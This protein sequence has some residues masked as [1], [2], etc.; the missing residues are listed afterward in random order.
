M[1]NNEQIALA[2]AE[3]RGGTLSPIASGAVDSHEERT[4]L[5]Q[6]LRVLQKRRWLVACS[7]AAIVALVS[8]IS[9]LIPKRYEATSKVLLDTEGSDT[10]G[11]EQMVLPIGFD[12]NTKL[13]TQIRIAESDTI[14]ISVIQQLGLDHRREFAGRLASERDTDFDTRG[15]EKRAQ[16]LV[17]FRKSL[18]VRLIPKTQIIEIHFR[19]RDPRLASEV[20]NAVANTYIEHNF[21]VKYKATRQTSEWLAQQLDDL[22]KHAE[23]SQENFIAYQ[24]KTGILGTDETH[25]IITEKLDELN[26]RLAEAEGDRI[27]KEAKYRIATSDNPELMANVLPESVLGALYRQ[28]AEAKARLAQMS[29]KYGTAYPP[30]VQLKAELDDLHDSVRQEIGRAGDRV[31]AEYQASLRSEQMLADSLDRQKQQAYKL[32]GA[33]IQYAIL[34]RDV[35]SSRDL[36][37]GLLKKLKEAGILAGL[38]SSNI[39]IIDPASVPVEPMEPK[40][41]LNIGLGCL[42]GLLLGVALAFVAENVDTSIRT[43][44]D[45]ES[46][47]SMP[48]FGIIPSVPLDG[49]PRNRLRARTGVP[50]PQLVTI[51]DRNSGPAEAFR[52]LRTSLLLCS[53]KEPPQV[54]LVSSSIAQEGKSFTAANLSVVL[55]QTGKDVLLIDTDMR[56]PTVHRSFGIPMNAGL[57]GCLAGTEDPD[58]VIVKVDD[59]PGLHVVASG[60]LPPYPSELL[61]SD[62]MP[63]LLERWR[64]QYRYI[65]VDTP[66]VLAVTDATVCAKL[67]DVVVL[68]ARSQQTGRQSLLR[69]RD[70]LRKVRAN[71][72]G[73]VVNDLAFNSV[74]YR[75]YYGYYGNGYHQYYNSENRKGEGNRNGNGNRD[76]K[77]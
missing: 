34:R 32:N 14:A 7:L 60:H 2:D 64:K 31:R 13:Q 18:H 28:H 41:P 61:A 1:N 68:I 36:Y 35:E 19:S 48:S 46:Y 75:Q 52:A 38:K 15:I 59:I 22:K 62:A 73:V 40:I 23:T 17:L 51:E 42:G 50:L 71:V 55:A 37:E 4:S 27:V 24:K 76:G 29:A 45:I 49:K 33:A 70:L 43:P 54:F 25:N 69:T 12:L 74:E 6:F 3:A 5:I 66:P 39:N 30:V 44:E 26:K 16:L 65:V 67:A 56:R 11:L 20:A 9:F 63:Q 58:S 10:L 72:V 77:H 8:V 57:S 53:P 21:Q 47:C